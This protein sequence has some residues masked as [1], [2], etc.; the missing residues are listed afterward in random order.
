[1][2]KSTKILIGTFSLLFIITVAVVVFM[3][4]TADARNEVSESFTVDSFQEEDAEELQEGLETSSEKSPDAMERFFVQ[5]ATQRKAL[6]NDGSDA[7]YFYRPGSESDKWVIWFEGGGGCHDEETCAE[8]AKTQSW[9]MTSNKTGEYAKQGGILSSST[10]ENPDF[11]EWNHAMLNYCSSDSWAGDAIQQ[12]EGNDVLFYGSHI[13]KAMFEDLGNSEIHD[14]NLADATQVLITGTSAG[15]G[16]ASHN[17]DRIA[18]WLPHA[19]VR[20]VIDSSWEVEYPSLI[21]TEEELEQLTSESVAYRNLQLDE[22]C[23]SELGDDWEHC[24]MISNIYPHW[25]VPVFIYIDQYDKKKLTTRFGVTDPND[26]E[27]RELMDGHAQ[28]IRDSL[29]GL[30][31]IF[32]PQQTWHGTINNDKFYRKTIDGFSFENVLTNWYFDREGP[33]ALI[34]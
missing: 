23:V 7:A 11:A 33:T 5:N 20:G 8:R 32:S 22:S 27:Q 12:V 15:G 9:L 3:F 6:C 2:T 16:G 10:E 24:S 4:I 29:Q 28:A 25:S 21:A 1:M 30:D 14:Q 31:G 13:T 17:M 34:K 26:S 19:D 18:Q